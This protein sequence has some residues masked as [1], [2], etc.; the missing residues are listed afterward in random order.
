MSPHTPATTD[1][2]FPSRRVKDSLLGNLLGL[3]T[4]SSKI[5]TFGVFQRMER[6]CSFLLSNPSVPSTTHPHRTSQQIF[7]LYI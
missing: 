1:V 5:L 7:M 4:K 3:P 6:V 2:K